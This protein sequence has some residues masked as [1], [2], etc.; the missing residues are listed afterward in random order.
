MVEIIRSRQ[1]PPVRTNNDL[2]PARSDEPTLE[3]DMI[4]FLERGVGDEFCDITLVSGEISKPVH[5]VNL[6][7]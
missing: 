6:S 2:Q 3:Q 5:K 1:S 4:A 7:H